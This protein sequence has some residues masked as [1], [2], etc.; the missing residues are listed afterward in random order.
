MIFLQEHE[1]KC[2][3]LEN[4]SISFRQ[5]KEISNSRSWIVFK[6]N[7]ISLKDYFR[8]IMARVAL[9]DLKLHP[10]DAVIA[11][12]NGNIVETIYKVQT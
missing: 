4:D 10:M 2:G 6:Q 7:S 9:F 12:L 3:S 8:T 5:A 1:E 11:F